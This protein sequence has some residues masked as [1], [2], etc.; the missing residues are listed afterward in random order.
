MFQAPRAPKGGN[1][2]NPMLQQ[3]IKTYYTINRF[4]SCFLDHVYKDMDYMV[5]DKLFLESIMDI[6]FQQPIEKSIFYSDDRYRFSCTLFYSNELVLLLFDTLL[7]CVIDLGTQNF[8]LATIIT[9]VVQMFV[10][11]LRSEIGKKNIS[12]QTMVEENFLI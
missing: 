5:K 9:F 3:R 4:L 2:K 11:I 1:E 10:K 7:F 12:M 8:V 6:A